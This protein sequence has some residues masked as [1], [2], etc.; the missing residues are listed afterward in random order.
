M[1][2]ILPFGNATLVGDLTGA[3]ILDLLNQ[4]A[5]LFKGALQVSGI[6]YSFYMYTDTLPGPQPWAWGAYNVTV[7]PSQHRRVR[8]A[9]DHQDLS[10]RHQRVPGA[11]R[12]G[13]LLRRSSTSRITRTGVI[14]SIASTAGCRRRIAR[15]PAPT[16]HTRRTHHP[17]GTSTYNPADPTQVIPVSVLHHNDSHGNLV[18]TRTWLIRN[19]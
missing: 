3:E 15:P 5:T 19:S 11:R 18:K 6:R 9:G 17:H 1:F 4:S 13:W 2:N 7:A 16:R 10:H 8:A 12:A 14:C